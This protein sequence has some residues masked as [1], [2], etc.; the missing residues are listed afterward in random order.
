MGRWSKVMLVRG[1][2]VATATAV[3]LAAP[4]ATTNG[5]A[6]GA[7]IAGA[8]GLG[9][10]VSVSFSSAARDPRASTTD[11]HVLG[12]NDLHGN[13]EAAGKT[14]YGLFAG[15]AAYPAKA[16]KDRQGQNPGRTATVY[17]GDNIG[18]APLANSLFHEEPVVI[19]SNLMNV[20][21]A[22]VGN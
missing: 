9:D 13:L 11:V 12:F 22:S 4:L 5:V 2:L 18:A 21:F 1:T 16:V 8:E 6:G 14:V 17:A 15:G 20:D 10:Q 19:A 3:V 7:T